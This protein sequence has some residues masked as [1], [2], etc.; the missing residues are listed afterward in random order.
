GMLAA[1]ASAAL[2]ATAGGVHLAATQ[3][4]LAA[5][6]SVA[7]EEA[8]PH[9]EGTE[10]VPANLEP[11][12]DEAENDN[13]AV[14][15]SGCHRSQSETD[16]GG[17]QVGENEDAPLVFLFGDSH[18]ASWY[19]ALEKLAEEG[20]IRLDSNTKS[21]C[22]SLDIAQLDEGVPYTSCEQWRD[23]VLERIDAEQPDLVI[24][25]NY[26]NPEL[27]LEGGNDDLADRWQEGL[28][29]TLSQIDGPE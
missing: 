19:P 3:Q 28:S 17:C 24:L 29:S 23:G 2:I 16:P 14:Y 4:S 8:D 9:P 13:A 11:S 25:A 22:Y 20:T 1:A 5:Q 7:A 21:S 6:Q 26:N 12:L 27:P 18:A 10:I 15:A